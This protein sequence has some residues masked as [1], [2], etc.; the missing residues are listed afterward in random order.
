M[1]FEVA[2]PTEAILRTALQ[3][4]ITHQ[5]GWWDAHLLAYAECLGATELYSEDF[6]HNRSYGQVR[7]V[8]PFLQV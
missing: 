6:Q 3:G 2:Y 1:E 8:N 5:M 4:A 7:V